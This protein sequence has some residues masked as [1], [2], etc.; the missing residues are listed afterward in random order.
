MLGD[1]AYSNVGNNLKNLREKSGMTQKELAD[2]LEV[3][4]TTISSYENGYSQPG[5]DKISR[6]AEIFRVTADELIS[7]RINVNTFRDGE[8][9]YPE[10]ERKIVVY[11]ALEDIINEYPNGMTTMSLPLA[12]RITG[13]LIAVRM[14]NE[15]MKYAGICVGDILVVNLAE[16]PKYG[17]VAIV[18]AEQRIHIGRYLKA[19]GNLVKVIPENPDPEYETITFKPGSKGV[20]IVG[21]V[22]KALVSI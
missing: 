17:D 13:N 2:L 9:I 4:N 6:L 12:D 18:A 10:N 1:A 16:K 3:E 21:R 8:N 22:I 20:R 19:G 7:G 15:A 5:I 14:P 11:R